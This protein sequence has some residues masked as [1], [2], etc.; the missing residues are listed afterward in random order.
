MSKEEAAW[1][2]VK[3]LGLYLLL[4]AFM[5]LPDL[6]TAIS[7]AYSYGNI[8]SSVSS[9]AASEGGGYGGML[10]Q[11]NDAYTGAYKN[12]FLG[13][14]IRIVLFSAVG[15]YLLTGGDFLFHLLSRQ[16]NAE[17]PEAG[18]LTLLGLTTAR[19]PNTHVAPDNPPAR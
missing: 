4:N 12:I 13:P 7:V 10:G 18:S 2:V 6:I 15:G 19:T 14:V 17:Q 5:G 3:V 1:L 16:P 9:L 11:L 8:L